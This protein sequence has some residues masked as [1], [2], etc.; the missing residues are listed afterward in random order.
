M[1][2]WGCDERLCFTQYKTCKQIEQL[3]GVCVILKYDQSTEVI[4]SHLSAGGACP[5]RKGG[6]LLG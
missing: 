3:K 2:T 6:T 1:N 5:A 4:L